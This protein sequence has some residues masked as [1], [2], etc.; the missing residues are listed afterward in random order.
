MSDTAV[1]PGVGAGQE[2]HTLHP[3]GPT[4]LA[5]TFTLVAGHSGPQWSR[6]VKPTGLVE[7]L[8]VHSSG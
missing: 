8:T 7:L 2:D 4:C 1:R 6:V 3:G 5:R